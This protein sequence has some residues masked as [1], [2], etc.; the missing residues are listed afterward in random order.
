MAISKELLVDFYSKYAPEKVDG[1]TDEKLQQIDS[2][3]GGDYK[4]M[5]TDLYAKYAPDQTIDDAK[6]N[7]ISE[8][9]GLKKKE[10]T[11]SAGG[12]GLPTGSLPPGIA[13]PTTS[14]E[15]EVSFY[16]LPGAKEASPYS[17]PNV[18]PITPKEKELD[19][20]DLMREKLDQANAVQD[21]LPEEDKGAEFEERQRVLKERNKKV[22][23]AKIYLRNQ[24]ELIHNSETA[25]E[26]F[27]NTLDA[28]GLNEKE[29]NNVI[30]SAEKQGEDKAVNDWVKKKLENTLPVGFTPQSKDALANR[31]MANRLMKEQDLVTGLEILSADQRRLYDINNELEELNKK[32]NKTAADLS[33]IAELRKSRYEIDS[34]FKPL[35]DGTTGK[36]LESAGVNPEDYATQTEAKANQYKETY[37]DKLASAYTDAAHKY[38]YYREKFTPELALLSTSMAAF[39]AS[40]IEDIKAGIAKPR[41][42]DF[43]RRRKEAI[44][45]RDKYLNAKQ[46][47][48]AMAQAYLVNT[49]PSGEI[50]GTASHFFKTGGKALLDAIV[51]EDIFPYG[52]PAAMNDPDGK[53]FAQAFNAVLQNKNIPL[54]EAQKEQAKTSFGESVAEGLGGLVGILPKLAIAKNVF[55]VA[56]DFA[57]LA[58]VVQRLE[59]GTKLEQIGAKLINAGIEETSMQAAGLAP[60]AGAGFAL[61]HNLLGNVGLKLKGPIGAIVQPFV[62]KVVGGAIGGTA[63][64]ETASALE[65]TIEGLKRNK[66]IS[67][68][69]DKRFPSLS[70]VGKRLASEFIVNGVF[71]MGQAALSKADMTFNVDKLNQLADEL[72]KSGNKVE[73]EQVRKKANQIA[74]VNEASAKL[75]KAEIQ[76]AGTEQFVA[77]KNVTQAEID[78]IAQKVKDNQEFSDREEQIVEALPQQVDTALKRIG[79]EPLPKAEAKTETTEPALT[80]EE[81]AALEITTP[82]EENVGKMVNYEGVEGVLQKDKEGNLFVHAE[83]GTE[84]LVEGGLSGKPAS[85]LGVRF[86]TPK[87]EVEVKEEHTE[88]I[89]DNQITFDYDNNIVNIYGKDYTYEGVET[90]AKG[91]TTALRVKDSKGKVKFIRNEDA[92]LE[93][94]IQKELAENRQLD[95]T[96]AEEITKTAKENEITPETKPVEPSEKTAE[97]VQQ[98]RPAEA[99]PTIEAEKVKVKPEAKLE[100]KPEEAKPAEEAKPKKASMLDELHEAMGTKPEAKTEAKPEEAK[101]KKASML[102]ELHEAMGTKPEKKPEAAKP[103]VGKPEAGKPEAAAKPGR[104][105]KRAA[106]IVTEQ[107]VDKLDETK[108][109][110]VQ[111]KVIKSAKKVVKAMAKVA[112]VVSKREAEDGDV[113]YVDS[114]F[115]GREPNKMVFDKGEWKSDVNGDLFSTTE[116]NQK[117]A[118]AKWS[119]GKELT[120]HVHDGVDSYTEAVEAAG[121]TAQQAAGSKGFWMSP[122]GEIHLNMAK[123]TAETMMHEGFHPVLDYIAENRPEMLDKLYDQ[124]GKVKGGQEVIDQA[125]KSYAGD[126]ETTIKKE[127]ITDYVAKVANGD[128]KIDRTNFEKVRDFIVK[129][130]NQL[131]FNVGLDIKTVEDLQDLARNISIKFKTGKEIKVK[132]I[133][134]AK[135]ETIETQYSKDDVKDDSPVFFDNLKDFASKS[136]YKDKIEFKNAVQDLLEKHIAELKKKY[137]K[138][139]DPTKQN[140]VTAKYVSDILTKEALNAIIAHPEA[141]GWYDEKTQ[142]ALAVLSL[143]HPEIATDKA[144]RGA[145]ITALAVTSNGNKVDSNFKLANEQYE[146]YKKNGRFDE[147]MEMG[148]QQSGIKASFA[149][150]NK[151]LEKGMK[152][153][154]INDFF[155]STHNA[156]DLKYRDSKTNKLASLVSGELKDEPVYGAT[157]LGSKIGNGFYMNL[158]GQFDQLTMDRWFMRTFGRVT[159]TLIKKDIEK[160]K[161][162]KKKIDE[163]LSD[164]KKDKDLYKSLVE[165]TGPISRLS[166]EKLAFEIEKISANKAKRSVLQSNAKLDELRKASNNLAKNIRGEKEAPANGS[167]RRFIRNVFKDIQ[168]KLKDEHNV[169]ISMAD[170]QAVLWYPEKVLYESFKE[171]ESYDDAMDDYTEDS[172]PDYLN[173]AKNLVKSNN[174]TDEQIN[175]AI[176]ERRKSDRIREEQLGRSGK[177]YSETE[178]TLGRIGE[179]KEELKSQR[180]VAEKAKITSQ[181][182]PLFSMTPESRKAIEENTVEEIDRIKKLD[183]KAEDGATMNLDGTKYE[184]GGLVVPVESIN[185]TQ[186][187]LTPKMIADFVEA[188]ESKI[189]EGSTFKVGLYK[190]PGKNQVSI[191][192]NIVVDPAHKDVALKFG[193]LAGQESLFNLDDFKNLKTGA[194]GANPRKFS[195]EQYKEIASALA[196]GRKPKIAGDEDLVKG[197]YVEPELTQSEDGENYVFYHVS[198]ADPKSIA[199]GIDSTKKYSTATSKAEKGS[200]YGVASFYTKPTDSERMIGGAKYT[201]SVPKEK[202]YPMNEDPNNYH[203]EAEKLYPEGTPDRQGKIRK[204]IA[205]SA[206]KDGY[207]MAVGEWGYKRTGEAPVGPAMRA[208]AL[209]PLKPTEVKQKG[210]EGP[211]IPHPEKDMLLAQEEVKKFAQKVFDM[212]NEAGKFDDL[213]HAAAIAKEDGIKTV[214]DFN[215]LT[216]DLKGD[217]AKEAEALKSTAEA[218]V[219][220]PAPRP[221]KGLQ[222]SMAEPEKMSPEQEAKFKNF[223]DRKLKEGE[224]ADD[225]KDVLKD[226]GLADDKISE[227]FGEKPKVSEKPAVA[228]KPAAEPKSYDQT[229]KQSGFTE[230]Q[231]EKWKQ[232]NKVSQRKE[233]IPTVQESAEK[234]KRGEITQAEYL[235]TVQEEQPVR[236]YEKVPALPSDLAVISS[237][238]KNKVETGIIGVTKNIPEG[239]RVATRLDIPAFDR[240]N[241]LVVSVHDGVKNGESI[242]YGKTAVLKNVEFESSAKRALE[243]ATGKSKESFARMFGDWKN[244]DPEAVRKRAEELIKD[245]EWTQVGMNPFRHSW[246]YDKKD[247]MPVLKADEVVQVGSLVLAKNIEKTTPD[248]IKF[249]AGEVKGKPIYFSKEGMSPEQE[250]KLKAFVEKKLQAGESIED[251]KDVLTDYGVAKDKIAELVGEKPKVEAV[252][253]T[254]SILDSDTDLLG[255]KKQPWMLEATAREAEQGRKKD[256]MRGS[257]F[258]PEKLRKIKSA[259]ENGKYEKAVEEGRMTA[260]DAKAI[261]ESAEFEVPKTIEDMAKEEAAQGMPETMTETVAVEKIT[262]QKETIDKFSE[263]T[264]FD[265]KL[266]DASG[267]KRRKLEAAREQWLNENPSMKA[268]YNNANEIIKQLEAKEL[269]TEKKGPCFS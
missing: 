126:P 190:F 212:K 231:V 201:V 165:L 31:M 71:G 211:P 56:S 58:T 104:P 218:A 53:K 82:L 65:G 116:E 15:E 235:K 16:G 22:D 77:P 203:A 44:A 79:E 120:L 9:Y 173:A 266:Q 223:I 208:D 244:E 232:D 118:A 162:G 168:S 61:S 23:Q 191:D 27:K 188:N 253:E 136:A 132:E 258:Y 109:G 98:E 87:P 70:E 150:I 95:N 66:T 46:E 207:E 43:E 124:L 128:I 83:D 134:N 214:A 225:I 166:S 45:L 269:I 125:K 84:V 29:I 183:K 30:D 8:V 80:E 170:L 249:K 54:T 198:G 81:K 59:Q 157:V 154:D 224:S 239:K 111:N 237:L 99:A 161:E 267:S 172:A 72:Y 192:L 259:I 220:K 1:L 135:G 73:A 143:M 216:K 248:N 251:I 50:K 78:K 112:K 76:G 89:P 47:F 260:F 164:I 230:S 184:G 110:E 101:P 179:S 148:K 186:G 178:K 24:G 37:K 88:P 33:K 85:E 115:A 97:Q 133:E 153:S 228:A 62:N 49:D 91:N 181:K 3:Y 176:A 163:L 26:G 177:P 13:A 147:S 102:D 250:A 265:Q 213:Y 127:A 40:D 117:A 247:G 144:S 171:G 38:Q 238:D 5:I 256:T 39:V 41:G 140:E 12:K 263:L 60:G 257:Q 21:V 52:E 7:K 64:M 36:A 174:I 146:Y 19:L 215:A 219:T 222:L 189:P 210:Y 48:D 69:L 255:E 137:G 187:K 229:V 122:D 261:I 20:Y 11:T 108:R 4:T 113:V 241:T 63:G 121:G 193:K 180:A 199:K 195:D 236:M 205:E 204:A 2:V 209:V 17:I 252:A 105:K 25:K 254:R 200:Q 167:E 151:L 131:G 158:W 6:I 67:E 119:E 156:G 169:D 103:E 182:K 240:Y 197:T 268:I 152:M 185:T 28:L 149:L 264:T 242:G 155:T 145:F 246:F 194:S 86:A 159:G 243:V 129:T 142:S 138:D 34:S 262:P 90:D 51:P 57:G 139:F 100:A 35:Y 75:A 18:S 106:E 96:T 245:P 74:G 141:I 227:L 68:E 123:V 93:F 233:R 202:V 14:K 42:A 217:L 32:Q 107:T 55:G 206:K 94:E 92:I 175:Q 196:E 114:K 130:L 221:K 10:S 160:V 234:L 226:Y